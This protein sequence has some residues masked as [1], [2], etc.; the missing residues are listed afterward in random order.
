MSARSL[1]FSLALLLL[2]GSAPRAQDD[3]RDRAQALERRAAERLRA[4]HDEADRLTREERSLLRDLRQLEV[5][6]DIRTAELE[7]A[8]VA[9][10]TAAQELAT[11]DA[12]AES[13]AQ[14]ARAALP[15]LQARIVTL[16]KLGRGQYARLLLSA[17]D[18]RQFG[19]AVRLVSALAEQDRVRLA[20]HKARLV[21]LEAARA[22][23][24]ERQAQVQQAQAALQKA[25]AAA[26]Q[27]IAARTALVEDIDSQR[28]LN[29]RFAAELLAAQE[30]LQ[31]SMDGLA[32]TSPTLPIAP[33]KGGLDWPAPGTVRQRFGASTGGRP[34][35]RGIEI[36]GAAGTPVR[37]VHEGTIA[38]ADVFSGYGRLVI[39]DHGNQT[40]SLYGNLDQVLV[41]K[42]AHVDHGTA[43]GTG[44]PSD[45]GTAV[46]YFEL[47][48]DGRAV[49]PL[50]WLAQR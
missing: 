39:V 2:A 10:R 48:I 49:D 13:L 6:R 50:Q 33:F 11:L 3:G 35:L 14:R 19:Q 45:D 8:R 16:Y 25:Q 31:A 15:D 17:S 43:L 36:A 27:A 40:F 5:D 47:R 44:A 28:D 38:F 34:P 9:V 32:S 21:D 30:R 46:V 24:R 20:E 41:E 7:Q 37:S 4:L 26:E 1:A 18:L 22:A 29:A 23:A 12:Q 42:G